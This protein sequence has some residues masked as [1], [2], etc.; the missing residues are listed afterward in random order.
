VLTGTATLYTAKIS[1]AA[2]Q[3]RPRNHF[4]PKREKKMLV[5]EDFLMV[6]TE[7]GNFV[8]LLVQFIWFGGIKKGLVKCLDEL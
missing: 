1:V 7:Y 2:N 8:L 5:C 4:K 6:F 3:K